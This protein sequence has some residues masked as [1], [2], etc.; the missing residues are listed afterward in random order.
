[1]STKSSN[2]EAKTPRKTSRG[3][4]QGTSRE[5]Q[6]LATRRRILDA[7]ILVFGRDGILKATTA[8]IAKEAGVAHGSIFVHF[9]SQEALVAAA[10][11]D[12]GEATARRLHET[13]RRGAGTREIL[14]AHLAG[15]R[16]REGFYA[17]LAAES[18][19]LPPEAKNGLVLMQSAI[20]FHLAPAVEADRK[21]KRIKAMGL[22]LLFNTWLGL[23]HYYLANRE[24]FS[25]GESVIDARGQE[26]LDHFMSLISIG[27]KG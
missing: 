27:G 15:I 22:G 13:M 16:E 10:I 11:D 1:M 3:K 7:A 8:A 6:K 17:R 4:R 23:L 26:L 21:A 14:A 2:T 18:S 12:F 19:L 24:L 25:P 9:G 20:A 5:A